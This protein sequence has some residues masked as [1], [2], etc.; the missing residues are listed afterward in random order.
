VA[1]A[2]GIGLAITG[3][4]VAAGMIPSIVSSATSMTGSEDDTVDDMTMMMMMMMMEQNDNTNNNTNEM[5]MS[6]SSPEAFMNMPNDS[7]ASSGAG[8]DESGR[9]A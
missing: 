5:V 9:M 3:V 6:D 8:D 1:R 4:L 7:L 2:V